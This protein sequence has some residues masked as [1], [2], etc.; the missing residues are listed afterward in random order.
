MRWCEGRGTLSSSDSAVG[1]EKRLETIDLVSRESKKVCARNWIFLSSSDDPLK[2][3]L[4]PWPP[5]GG[6]WDNTRP[7]KH[8]PLLCKYMLCAQEHSSVTRRWFHYSICR[9]GPE[10][11]QFHHD[12]HTHHPHL[13]LEHRSSSSGL[14]RIK[15]MER[16][17]H[18]CPTSSYL[19][20]IDINDIWTKLPI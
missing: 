10:G 7:Q 4:D 16:I 1:V 8:L 17:K 6:G 13:H 18:L 20:S 11:D 15:Q 19:S 12:P 9:E 2:A 5:C 3:S 14:K